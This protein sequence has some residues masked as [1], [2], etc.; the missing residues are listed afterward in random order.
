ME[1][2]SD[3]C[4]EKVI[5][6]MFT[7]KHTGL[8]I[9][10]EAKQALAAAAEQHMIRCFTEANEIARISKRLTI[11]PR[12]LEHVMN[13]SG[14]VE[15]KSFAVEERLQS[16]RNE[17]INNMERGNVIEERLRSQRNERSIDLENVIEDEKVETNKIVKDTNTQDKQANLKK[18]DVD[19]DDVDEDDVVEEDITQ[20]ICI[21]CCLNNRDIICVPCGHLVLCNECQKLLSKPTCPI[22]RKDV[23]FM[24]VIVS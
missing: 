9:T 13:F 8:K 17:R 19:E 3:K 12:D 1:R 18:D 23:Q 22:C 15:P 7:S 10:K 16:Q 21:A 6:D 2:K 24:K 11:L 5:H 14:G 20:G 4:I